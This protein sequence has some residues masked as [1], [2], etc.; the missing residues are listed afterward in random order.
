MGYILWDVDG[1]LVR[2]GTDAGNL[3]HEAVELAA[4]RTIADKLPNRHGKTDGQILWETLAAHG[5][6]ASLHAAAALHL[7][8][9]SRLRHERGEHRELCPGVIPALAAT[10]LAGWTNALLTGNGRMRS[11]YKI[12]GAGIDESAIDWEHSYFGNVTPIRSELTRAAAT[13]LDGAL[14]IVGDTPNDGV[15]ADAAGL[16]FLAVATGAFTVDELR[17]TSA[18]IVIDDLESG[19]DALLD[20][21]SA[22]R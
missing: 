19:L 16:P 4:G 18:R 17:A 2:N 7:D 11:F 14:V 21:L 9:L 13:D 15:A 3:Y 12:T 1:T 6:P 5:L 8:E 20:Q 10:R 22:L